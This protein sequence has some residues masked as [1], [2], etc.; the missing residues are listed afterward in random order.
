MNLFSNLFRWAHRQNENFLTESFSYV[1]DYLLIHEPE[2]GIGVLTWLCFGDTTSEG[3]DGEV[4]DISLQY[5]DDQGIPDIKVETTSVLALVEV[6]KGSGLGHLQLER[7]R[8]IL[9]SS[10]HPTKKL[11]LLTMHPIEFNQSAERPDRQLT[12]HDV[13]E[14]FRHCP[15]LSDPVANFLVQQFIEFLEQQRMSVQRVEKEYLSGMEA[16]VRLVTMIDL[17]LTIAEIPKYKRPRNGKG[18]WVF[19]VGSTTTRD[20]CIRFY[21]K[22][23]GELRFEFHGKSPNRKPFEFGSLW[24]S[25]GQRLHRIMELDSEFFEAD[26]QQQLRKLTEFLRSSHAEAE[27]LALPE[28]K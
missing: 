13:S 20:Y 19:Y 4:P 25:G 9:A 23:P 16:Y 15:D 7:Y 27:Q 8:S 2:A 26:A 24:K 22:R 17:A 6:K 28:Q 12:W 1:V 3:F 18:Y 21:F 11:V 14:W 10:L 5:R